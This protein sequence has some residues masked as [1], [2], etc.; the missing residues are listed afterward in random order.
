MVRGDRD[1][2]GRVTGGDGVAPA[3]VTV[4][5]DVPR[6]HRVD[7]LGGRARPPG[8]RADLSD[9]AVETALEHGPVEDP[10]SRHEPPGQRQRG[11]DSG[12]HPSRARSAAPITPP[13]LPSADTATSAGWTI[14]V[15]SRSATR[16]GSTSLSPARLSPPPITTSAGPTS[17]ET[18]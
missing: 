11:H 12:A 17:S 4:D 9:R 14:G 8:R 10:L 18:T 15:R 16:S 1:D 2:L 6:R 5:V 7:R 13:R 3:A